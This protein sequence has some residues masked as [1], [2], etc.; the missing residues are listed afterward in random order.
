M[1]AIHERVCGVAQ[2]LGRVSQCS[3]D[4]RVCAPSRV[5]GVAVLPIKL[6]C[7]HPRPTAKAGG[8]S[9]SISVNAGQTNRQNE[10]STEDEDGPPP[11][12]L[13]GS[14]ILRLPK[15]PQLVSRR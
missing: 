8:L 5:D 13:P 7:A 6:A 4:S 11:T 10:K 3:R 2:A 12:C 14:Q 1:P 15:L 9:C